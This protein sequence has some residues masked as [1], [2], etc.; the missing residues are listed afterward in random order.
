MINYYELLLWFAWFYYWCIKQCLAIKRFKLDLN[1]KVLG[2]KEKNHIQESSREQL[3]F[4]I[5]EGL[6]KGVLAKELC[7]THTWVGAGF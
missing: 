6:W 7:T 3:S 1:H 4:K 2:I 5:V